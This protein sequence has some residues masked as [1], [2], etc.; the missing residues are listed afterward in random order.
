[1][2]HPNALAFYFF[3]SGIKQQNFLKILFVPLIMLP[4]GLALG[5]FLYFIKEP[6]K[7]AMESPYIMLTIILIWILLAFIIESRNNKRFF[8]PPP[9]EFGLN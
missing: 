6:L 8:R 1:M 9:Y 4:Y 5:Y 3:N 2:L 7:R